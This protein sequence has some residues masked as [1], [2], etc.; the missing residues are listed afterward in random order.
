MKRRFVQLIGVAVVLVF[1]VAAP[2]AGAIA[3]PLP[4]VGV[5]YSNFELASCGNGGPGVVANGNWDWRLIRQELAA[6][7]AAGIQTLR[8]FIWNTHD[9]SGQTWGAVS[10]AGGRLGP[11]E[12]KNLITF[13]SAVRALGFARL[14]VAFSPQGANDPIGYPQNNYDPS[15]FEEN[16]QLIGYVRGIV[17]QY[18]PL[19][20][21]FDILNEGAPFDFMATKTQLEAYVAHMY[22]NY[23]DAFGNDDVTVSVNPAVNDQSDLANLVDTLRSTGRPLPTWFEVHI[24]GPDSLGDLRA[25]DATLSAKDLS[26]PIAVGETYYDDP[27]AASAVETF[28]TTSPRPLEEVSAWPLARGSTCQNWSVS[29]PYKADAF[30][31]ALTG[32][33]PPHN[34]VVTLGPGHT[35]SLETPY[36]QPV[37]ALEAGRY[38]FAIADRSRSDNFHIIGPAVNRTTGRRFRGDKTWTLRLKPGTYRY[39]SDRPNSH[40][41]GGFAALRAG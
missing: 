11:T 31:T 13:A 4:L 8:T 35:L 33:P 7:R 27:S 15:L 1:V 18:G 36:G 9:A 39:R 3:D 16:W 38:S 21:R 28:V 19:N 2:S 41:K 29:P 34:I 30:I 10:S 17:K 14:E 5:N 24:Y 23:V 12:T 40:L 22:S 37:T 20:T 32:N 25:I 26:Q 6:M